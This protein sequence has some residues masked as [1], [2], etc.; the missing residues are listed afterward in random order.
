M[1]YLS[2][3]GRNMAMSCLMAVTLCL[4]LSTRL[5]NAQSAAE[6][7]SNAA[8]EVEVA[9]T[10]DSSFKL[11]DEDQKLLD[12]FFE[13]EKMQTEDIFGDGFA[14]QTYGLAPVFTSKGPDRKPRLEYPSIGTVGY[15]MEPMSSYGG[16]GLSC[17]FGFVDEYFRGRFVAI[18][19][20]MYNQ[21]FTCGRCVKVQCD[22]SS[23]AEPGKSIVAQVVDLC[24]ECFDGDMTVGGSLFKEL[25]GRNPNP[26][27]SVALSWEFTECSPFINSTIK[28]L[29]KPGGSAY[30]QAFNFA[31][32]KQPILAA[33]VNGDRLKHES[34]NFWSWN[35]SRGAINPRGPFD[36]A[37]LGANR[38]VIRVRLPKLKSTD[39]TIQ[40]ADSRPE[41]VAQSSANKKP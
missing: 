1:T 10:K 40:F 39:L 17:G 7:F 34:N 19:K 9:G 6:A 25:V 26:N 31:N 12:G 21:G 33:Q 36:I 22:D 23:C 35:P 13:P 11:S 2:S 8:S 3:S 18:G 20:S 16:V 28:M 14:S 29:I 32:A 30:Y 15:G 5:A 37:L 24:G 41:K 38:Q 27:P 4:A